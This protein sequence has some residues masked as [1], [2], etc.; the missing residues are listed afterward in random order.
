LILSLFY[1]RAF[2][3]A[4]NLVANI[5]TTGFT[6]IIYEFDTSGWVILRGTDL[7]RDTGDITLTVD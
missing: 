2:T 7:N 3:E 5:L 6:L 1:S 4:V